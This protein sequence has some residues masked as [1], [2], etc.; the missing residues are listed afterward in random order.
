MVRIGVCQG[1][2]VI[3]DVFLERGMT[4]LGLE[5]RGKEY[6]EGEGEARVREATRSKMGGA[7]KGSVIDVD[8]RVPP[9]SH[10]SGAL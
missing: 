5:S 7:S 2:A 1:V 4:K 8:A 9:K 10:T 3:W 6:I